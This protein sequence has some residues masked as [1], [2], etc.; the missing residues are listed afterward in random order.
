[1]KKRVLNDDSM[2]IEDTWGWV[3][4]KES[5]PVGKPDITVIKI[6]LWAFIQVIIFF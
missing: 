1:M 2:D 3:F 4:F 5:G 6:F